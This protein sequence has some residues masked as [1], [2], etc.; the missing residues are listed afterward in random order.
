MKPSGVKAERRRRR[1][2]LPIAD[3]WR[4]QSHTICH[5]RFKR[6]FFYSV[7]VLLTKTTPVRVRA[8]RFVLLIIIINTPRGSTRDAMRHEKSMRTKYDAHHPGNSRLCSLSPSSSPSFSFFSHSLNPIA[9]ATFTTCAITIGSGMF[10]PCPVLKPT[11]TSISQLAMHP[12]ITS[13]TVRFLLAASAVAGPPIAHSSVTHWARRGKSRN[14]WTS[15]REERGPFPNTSGACKEPPS[16]N[17]T[18]MTF[19]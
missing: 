2:W 8:R 16:A 18:D 5:G 1:L 10:T 4:K 14:A 6:V 11:P 17:K 3:S 13:A 19:R 12:I 7:R 15:L 9:L